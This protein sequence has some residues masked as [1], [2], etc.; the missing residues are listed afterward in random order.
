MK[1]TPGPWKFGLMDW[2]NNGDLILIEKPFDYD[3][4]GHTNNPYILGP[5]NEEVAGNDEYYVFSNEHDARLICAAPEM[6]DELIYLYSVLKEY[7]KDDDAKKVANIIEKATGMTI[8]E[9]IK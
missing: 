2:D 6:L 5:N 3:G 1:H 9:I 7:A 8:G 4:G